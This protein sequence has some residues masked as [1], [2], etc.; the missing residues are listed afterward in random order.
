VQFPYTKLPDTEPRP[1]LNIVLRHGFQTSNIVK[2]VV[3]SGADYPLFPMETATSYLKL[4]LAQ[5]ESWFFSGTTG[6]MQTAKPAEVFM[7]VLDPL[8]SGKHLWEVRTTCAFCNTLEMFGGLFLGRMDFSRCLRLR[9]ISQ[10]SVLHLS[11][12]PATWQ[13]CLQT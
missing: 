12:G 8:D 6:K 11:D 10:N 7:A 2:A 4:D 1:Y 9:S 3:D 13:A 5:A